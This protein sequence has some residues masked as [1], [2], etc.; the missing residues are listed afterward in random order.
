MTEPIPEE[1]LWSW[2]DR[3]APELRTHLEAHPED[4]PR[5]TELR[6]AMRALVPDE[7]RWLPE[8]FGPY[9]VL[10]RI[11]AG[12][13]GVVYEAR[14]RKLRRRV[15]LKVIRGVWLDDLHRRRM[16]ERE[17]AALAR[18]EHPSLA[19]VFETGETR[20][21][22]PWF[23]ME[24]A[25][26][27]PLDEWARS[28]EPS[29]KRRLQVCAE[30][31]RG[32]EHAHEQGVIHRDLKPSNVHVAPDGTIKVLDFGLARVVAPDVAF[33]LTATD[34][35]QI[36]GTVRYMSPEQA[37]GFVDQV[38]RGSDIYSLGVLAYELVTGTSPHALGDMGFLQAVR[39]VSE[40]RVKRPRD[41]SPAVSREVSLDLEAVLLKALELRPGD[42][43]ASMA[44][45][46][47]DLEQAAEGQAVQAP[48]RGSRE[49][50]RARLV[51]FLR[52]ERKFVL[53]ELRLMGSWL[54][55]LGTE[56]RHGALWCWSK[57]W[58]GWRSPA[59]RRFVRRHPYL[60]LVIALGLAYLFTPHFWGE[61]APEIWRE[62][63]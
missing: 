33:S 62:L 37:G 49:V 50:Y 36:L 60:S 44:E 9:K 61:V 10:S 15:A 7:P 48:L 24:L 1:Q 16:F 41:I 6:A 31:A 40:G 21:G 27:V 56:L 29:L 52:M 32:V 45:F 54:G 55:W 11:G 4:H 57:L 42:R 38:G 34:P 59:R 28:N 30:I 5:V 53:C 26:G 51:G 47:Q 39:V 63:F 25:A 35:G 8:E 22:A 13:M 2:I 43:Y 12:G 46:A 23:A 3:D 18:L 20:E 14:H 17:S 19:T 58:A